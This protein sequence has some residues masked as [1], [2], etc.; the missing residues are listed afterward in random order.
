MKASWLYRTAAVFFLLFALGHTV[1]FLHFR[2]AT[3]EGVA[4]HDAM[5]S[6][7]LE[8]NSDFT[9][10][11]FYTGSGLFVSAY[12]LF[13]AFLAWHLG[14][15]SSKYP[16]AVGT[17]GWSFFALQLAC[18]VLSWIYFP[19]VPVAISGLQVVLLGWAAWMV[20]GPK[21]SAPPIGAE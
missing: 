7:R 3:A 2:P 13:S 4:V 8:A 1:G 5:N 14:V 21:A 11:K 15:L 19:A 12:M 10:G 20:P 9:Y 6:V 18:L 16:Q 17:L